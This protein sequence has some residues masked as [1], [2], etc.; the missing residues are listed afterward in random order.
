MEIRE[1]VQLAKEFVAHIYEGDHITDIAFEGHDFDHENKSWEITIGFMHPVHARNI[2]DT[3]D[4]SAM[5]PFLVKSLQRSYKVVRINP[6]SG[7]VESFKDRF[8]PTVS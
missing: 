8:L 6:K 5:P 2:R 3:R 4:T 7:K 1:A